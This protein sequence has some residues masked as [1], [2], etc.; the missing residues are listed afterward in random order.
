MT[1]EQRLSS[2]VVR[3][4]RR[5]RRGRQRRVPRPGDA[6][7][8]PTWSTRPTTWSATTRASRNLLA[9]ARIGTA[10]IDRCDLGTVARRGAGRRARRAA[11]PEAMRPGRA[12]RA[13]AVTEAPLAAAGTVD[14]RR[15]WRDARRAGARSS[16]VLAEQAARGRGRRPARRGR[17]SCESVSWTMA[18]TSYRFLPWARRGLA[19]EL[20]RH[21]HRRT[22]P[23]AGARRRR[24]SA[25][26]HR[27]RHRRRATLTLLRAGR[28]PRHRPAAD[29]AHRA[30]ARTAPTS[31]RTTSRRS[32]STR[33][34]SRGCS[35]PPRPGRPAA[36]A[37]VRPRRASTAPSSTPP[38]CPSAGAAAGAAVAGAGRRHRAARP[39][40]S[41]GRGRTRRSPTRQGAG[42]RDAAELA[43]A[44]TSTSRGWSARGA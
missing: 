10:R 36:A 25:D 1:E 6:G 22:A 44:P 17:S 21:R 34:T 35:R 30:R 15:A 28:R 43:A 39:A 41:R 18:A 14:M 9:S 33:P 37:V 7:A 5:R 11:G 38:H 19:A 2:P 23:A 31:S 29:R 42:R 24:P 27:R 32:S 13:I 16:S 40:P 8:G 4:L 20:R 12:R 3:A 26:D